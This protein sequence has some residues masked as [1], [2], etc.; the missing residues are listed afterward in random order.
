MVTPFQNA[1]ALS[2]RRVTILLDGTV[3]SNAEKT[4]VSKRL[5]FYFKSH[6]FAVTFPLNT[7]R[8]VQATFFQSFD[9]S[10]PS[11]GKPLGTPIFAQLGAVEYMTG[12]DET[13]V[14]RHETVTF[15]AGAFLKLYLNNTD[16]FNHNIFAFAELEII[17]R[18]D[19]DPAS[20]GQS[21]PT[22][23]GTS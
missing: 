18:P 13:V 8:T 4:L 9:P 16:G 23:P 3:L 12:D 2:G 5:P 6:R 10:A 21:S 17:G 22:A 11:S 20:T 15:Q 19:S 14:V 7:N 1:A